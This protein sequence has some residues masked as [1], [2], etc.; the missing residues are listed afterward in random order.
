LTD[1]GPL[2]WTGPARE[3]SLELPLRLEAGTTIELLV[4]AAMSE[5]ILEELA[6]EVNRTP[7]PLLREP[8]EAGVVFR[9]VLP[10]DYRSD[11]RFT[12]L[13]IRTV[14]TV[15]WK[16]A[17][18]TSTDDTELGVAVSWVRLGAPDGP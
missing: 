8:A 7:V 9:G 5:E 18:P 12:R 3:A 1:N 11:R 10:S 14:E 15:P 16:E 13:V 17:D 2:R 4:A 6:V